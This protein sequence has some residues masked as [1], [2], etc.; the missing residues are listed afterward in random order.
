MNTICA[1]I[2]CLMRDNNREVNTRLILENLSLLQIDKFVILAQSFT[3]S[4]KAMLS[5][6]RIEIIKDYE[7]GVGFVKSRN[8]LLQWFY[9]SDYDYA[10]WI[11][12]NEKVTES[13]L[14]S[15][16]TV[17]DAIRE[18]K[19][20]VD[21]VFSSLGI[22]NNAERIQLASEDDYFKVCKLLPA[23]RYSIRDLSWLHFCFMKNL[24]K[25]YDTQLYID[26]K[27]D[28]REGLPEDAYLS[29]LLRQH[30]NCY[31][32]PSITVSKPPATTSTWMHDS[33]NVQ[34]VASY[35]YPPIRWSLLNEMVRS[36]IIPDKIKTPSAQNVIELQRVD[37]YKDTLKPYRPRKKAKNVSTTINLF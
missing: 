34:G 12:A 21:A 15:Y 7:S 30:V 20:D 33:T 37:L 25:Y 16:F 5:D 1:L 8:D 23:S 36:N 2:P 18:N 27:C 29:S 19:V 13:T 28:P 9:D 26:E 3:A 35:S 10:L 17:L 32:A 11:D 4:D 6:P 14:N 31:L 22:M 24:R